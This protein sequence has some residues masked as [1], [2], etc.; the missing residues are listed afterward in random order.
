MCC[1][2]QNRGSTPQVQQ[3]APRI[4]HFLESFNFEVGFCE[5][6]RSPHSSA[7][8]SW[9]RT[10]WRAM[11]ADPVDGSA[12]KT[13]EYKLVPH[14]DF[15]LISGIHSPEE[16][17]QIQKWEIRDTDIFI[18]TYPKSGTIWLQQIVS[19]IEVRGNVTATLDQLNAIRIPWMEMNVGEEFANAPSP[20][21]R[22]T[23]LHYKFI[24]L[25]LKQKRGKVIYVARN[26]KDIMVSYFHFHIYA[27]MLETPKD[28]NSFFERFME[29]KVFGNCWFEHIKAWYSHRQEMN[30][31]YIT[32]EDLIQDLSAA[33]DRICVFL[34]RDLTAQ[35]KENVVKHSTFQNMRKNPTA[36]YQ[37]MPSHFNHDKGH[38]MRKGMVGDWKNY[39]T[40]AQNERFDQ[41]FQEKM[42][43]LPLT[44]VW[45]IND[46][47]T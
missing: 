1:Q 17:D 42:R 8:H 7:Y 46:I 28:F 27:N 16:I 38:F 47:S 14:R 37:A 23:H 21:L 2:V 20:R 41:A 24:P 32:Y 44:F 5:R 33:V 35:E 25:G 43:D 36:N 40:V 29:G 34:E 9:R 26:P 6:K 22:V 4:E 19:M 18:I 12:P 13:P 31:L 30:F 39:F 15:Y 11:M 45:E 10:A 3:V